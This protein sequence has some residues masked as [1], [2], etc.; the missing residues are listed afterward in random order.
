MKKSKARWCLLLGLAGI[1]VFA[2]SPYGVEKFDVII[3]GGK[4]IDGT[5]KPGFVGDVAIRGEKIVAV[6]RVDGEA[7]RVIDAKGLIVC[8]GFVEN[9]S[10]ADNGI[11]EYPMAENYIMQGVTTIL[12]GGCGHMSAP[13]PDMTYAEWTSKVDKIGISINLA[14]F[15]GLTSNIRYIVMGTDFKRPATKPEIEKMK[16]LV[17]DAMKNGAFGMSTGLS[18]GLREFASDEEMIECGKV[19]QKYGGIWSTH[20]R[21]QEN[22]WF[23]TD[24]KD[25]GY[26]TNYAPPGEAIAGRFH[27]IAESVELSGKANS[28]T[29]LIGHVNPGYLVPMPHP[30]YL[31]AAVAR[32]TIDMIIDPARKK[33]RRL[34]HSVIVAS[35]YQN[36]GPGPGSQSSILDTFQLGIFV[37]DFE[38]SPRIGGLKIHATPDWLKKM[39]KEEFLAQLKTKEFREKL[40]KVIYT[41]KM[42]FKYGPSRPGPLLDGL[43]PDHDA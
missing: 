43:L 13:T 19:V 16:A 8:P 38:K 1:L 12:S 34:F 42:K 40:K 21:W 35:G 2:S 20:T 9:Q 15:V 33:G 29:H 14:Q 18:P 25:I 41:G 17:E 32:A 26:G 23:R 28:V 3:K 31:D 37:K 30:E 7:E 36:A 39:T 27:G 5:G 4:I 10:H 22:D 6:G 11:L 24:P